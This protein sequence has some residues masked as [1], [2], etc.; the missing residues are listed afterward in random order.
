MAGGAAAGG[1]GGKPGHDPVVSARQLAQ[2]KRASWIWALAFTGLISVFVAVHL[3]RTLF[4][5]TSS[6]R[7]SQAGTLSKALAAPFR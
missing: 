4:L 3:I 6:R 1:H 7:R 5:L 2:G